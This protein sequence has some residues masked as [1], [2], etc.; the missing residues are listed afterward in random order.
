[1]MLINKKKSQFKKFYLKK[2]FFDMPTLSPT[3][4]F[5]LGYKKYFWGQFASIFRGSEKVVLGIPKI[6]FGVK[7]SF[8]GGGFIVLL[9]SLYIWKYLTNLP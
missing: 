3:K 5:F 9:L 2:Y 7:N 4:I 8:F 1:M 6:Y